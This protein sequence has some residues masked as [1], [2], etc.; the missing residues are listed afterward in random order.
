MRHMLRAWPSGFERRTPAVRRLGAAT[1][2]AI[3][4]L[5]V[6]AAPRPSAAAGGFAFDAGYFDMTNARNSAKAVFGGSAGGFTFGTAGRFDLKPRLFVGVAVRYFQRKGER[7]FVA[8]ANSP[9]FALGHPLTVRVIPLY[10]F[11]GYRFSP[12]ASLVPYVGLGAGATLL[13]EESTVAQITD[14]ADQTKGAFH[15][16][17]GV[18][19]GRGSLRFGVELSYSL[20]PN[21][22]G[23]GGVSKVYGE[24]DIGGLSAVARVIL[25]P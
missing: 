2:A 15:L 24:S 11:A 25:V 7:V 4:L 5:A 22:I 21:S 18:E 13:H 16:I 6:L 8:D 10:A 3:G 9:P 17:G 1:V 12:V 14:S 20:V 23:V 19:Y